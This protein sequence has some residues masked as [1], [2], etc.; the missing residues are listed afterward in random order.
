MGPHAA[1]CVAVASLEPCMTLPCLQIAQHCVHLVQ[2]GA[3][4]WHA[5]QPCST[6]NP[7]PQRCNCTRPLPVPAWR[8]ITRVIISIMHQFWQKPLQSQ[9]VFLQGHVISL[10]TLRRSA[11]PKY[12]TDAKTMTNLWRMSTIHDVH[13]DQAILDCLTMH[14]IVKHCS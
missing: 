11:V 6:V 12:N 5:E 4:S 13:Y 14:P 7:H 1:I 10:H 8:P 2:S 9:T 3:G